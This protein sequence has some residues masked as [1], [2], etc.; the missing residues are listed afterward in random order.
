MMLDNP[1]GTSVYRQMMTICPGSM[2]GKV[3]GIR[4]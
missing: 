3:V 2:L 1:L 4:Y